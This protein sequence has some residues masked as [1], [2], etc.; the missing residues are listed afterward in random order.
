MVVVETEVVVR[1][2]VVIVERGTVA[3]VEDGC[4][5]ET[6]WSSKRG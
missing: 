6:L 4:C 3:I 2:E 1:R 5:R